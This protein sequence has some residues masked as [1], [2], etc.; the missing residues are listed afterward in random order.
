MPQAQLYG[1]LF[2][3]IV[4]ILTVATVLALLVFGGTFKRIVEQS[5]AGA[6]GANSAEDDYKSRMD[7]ALLLERLLDSKE[8]LLQRNYSDDNDGKKRGYKAEIGYYTNLT[9]MLLNIKPPSKDGKEEQNANKERK[10][11]IENYKHNYVLA[12]RKCQ[13]KPGGSVMSGRPE[14]RFEAYGRSYAGCG[15]TNCM[16]A[17]YKRSYARLYESLACESHKTDDKYVKLYETQ[18]D[19]IIGVNVRLEA[20]NAREHLGQVYDATNGEIYYDKK[21]YNPYEIWGYLNVGPFQTP[22]EMYNSSIFTFDSNKQRN[23]ASFCIKQNVTDRIIGIVTLSN[24]DP[25]NLSI[26]LDPPIL[27]PHYSINA[28]NS[29]GSK[30]QLEACYLLMDRLFAY[31]YRRISYCIDS[32]DRNN[33]KLADRLGFTYEGTLLK[34]MIIKESSRDSNIYG[35]LNSDW[36]AGARQVL[37]K[38]LYGV[39]A[40]KR[41]IAM[42]KKEE[43]LDIQNQ[44][45]EKQKQEE[46]EPNLKEENGQDK[47]KNA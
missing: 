17:S 16:N 37:Y 30:E 7:R 45:L 22:Q 20:L 9:K 33:S 1:I 26:Q 14:A 13:D 2:G 44:Y 4:F 47:D 24:D 11:E 8:Y 25:S 27:N 35:M 23:T 28:K 18:P 29:T 42:N 32:K 6:N 3:C 41:D 38:K 31:G 43:E 40:M 39:A 12:Y 36:D 19:I 34:H 21:S 10:V 46:N 5:N 15:P